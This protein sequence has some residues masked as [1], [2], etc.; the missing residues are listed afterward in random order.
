MRGPTNRRIGWLRWHIVD[1]LPDFPSD[2]SGVLPQ[3]GKPFGLNN[4]AGTIQQFSLY[5]IGSSY[6]AVNLDRLRTKSCS[7]G[8]IKGFQS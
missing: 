5:S 7:Q 4:K 1:A 6:T 8:T 2:L 3:G